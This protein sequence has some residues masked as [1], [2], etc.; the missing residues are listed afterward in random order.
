M[1]KRKR[2]NPADP[3]DLENVGSAH[4]QL[5]VALQ[6]VADLEACTTCLGAL[7]V[8]AR[9][10]LTSYAELDPREAD[11]VADLVARIARA[12]P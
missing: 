9:E 10:F 1:T 2:S 6:R 5:G 7:L 8:E 12:W 4:A 3:I 11:K